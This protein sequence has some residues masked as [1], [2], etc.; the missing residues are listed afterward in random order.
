MD[1]QGDSNIPESF[2]TAWDIS[3]GKLCPLVVNSVSLYIH[4]FDKI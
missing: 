3:G 2:Q 4:V 1:S